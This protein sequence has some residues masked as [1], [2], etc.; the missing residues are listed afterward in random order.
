MKDKIT[1]ICQILE[2]HFGEPC[3]YDGIDNYMH[4]NK[5]IDKLCEKVCGDVKPREC[6]RMYLMHRIFM[7][8]ITD[9]L[10]TTGGK[11]EIEE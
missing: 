10:T 1:L 4:N 2:E 9:G 6:W 11:E 7:N 8:E 5:E 3:Q